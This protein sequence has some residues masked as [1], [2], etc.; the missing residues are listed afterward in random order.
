MNSTISIDILKKT[1]EINKKSINAEIWD[2]SSPKDFILMKSIFKRTY[3]FFL[4]F[5]LSRMEV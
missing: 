5:D 3:G 4:V 2:T 1:I